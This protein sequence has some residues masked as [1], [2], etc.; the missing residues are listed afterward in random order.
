MIGQRPFGAP[1]T[2]DTFL[3]FVVDLQTLCSH[4]KESPQTGYT[5]LENRHYFLGYSGSVGSTWLLT[6]DQNPRQTCRLDGL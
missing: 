6:T 5:V 3:A 2:Q 4:F 1:M